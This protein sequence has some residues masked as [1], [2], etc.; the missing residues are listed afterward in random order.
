MEMYFIQKAQLNI[1]LEYNA[2]LIFS[3]DYEDFVYEVNDENNQ[4]Q[5]A[6]ISL[7]LLMT[8]DKVDRTNIVK[9]CNLFGLGCK[10][11]QVTSKKY[12]SDILNVFNEILKELYNDTNKIANKS[13]KILNLHIVKFKGRPQNKRYKNSVKMDTKSSDSNTFIQDNDGQGNSQGNR[14]NNCNTTNHNI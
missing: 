4:N 8:I 5:F 7:R 3:E 10:I 11:A 14:C 13:N 9:I 6:Q 12:R 1:S 2:T